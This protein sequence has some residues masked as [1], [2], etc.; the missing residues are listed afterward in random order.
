MDVLQKIVQV[1]ATV[2]IPSGLAVGR[3]TLKVFFEQYNGDYR[4]DYVV[5]DHFFAVRSN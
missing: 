1:E 4:T 5:D 3:Y 2:T